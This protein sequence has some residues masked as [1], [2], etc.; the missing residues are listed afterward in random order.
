MRGGR[1]EEVTSKG[2]FPVASASI[3]EQRRMGEYPKD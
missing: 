3:R 1:K 2:A